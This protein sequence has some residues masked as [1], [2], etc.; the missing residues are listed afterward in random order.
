MEFLSLIPVIII[1]FLPIL[2][3]GYVFSYLDNSSLGARRFGMGILAG[4]I[5]VVP[6]LFLSD[7]MAS[8]DLARWNVFPLLLR[9]DNG[10]DLALSLAVT[11]GLIA[12]SVFV[13]SVGIFFDHI[14]KSWQAFLRNTSIVLG[15]GVLF[16]V[17]HTLVFPLDIFGSSLPNG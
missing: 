8:A 6:V 10:T 13:F 1:T 11:V 7:M 4:A 14:G 2:L 16:A 9:G 3:W 17:L 12:A 15:I 5:S